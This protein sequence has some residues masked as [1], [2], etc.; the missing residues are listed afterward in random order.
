M[1]EGIKWQAQAERRWLANLLANIKAVAPLQRFL[2][3]TDIR[4]REGARERELQWE[5]KKDRVGETCVNKLRRGEP[6]STLSEGI[7]DG[8]NKQ[9]G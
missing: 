5:Q 7:E 1:K 9:S 6:K 8:E 2:K 4:E 3:V